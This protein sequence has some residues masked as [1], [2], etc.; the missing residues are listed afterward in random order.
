LRGA[1]IIAGA[2]VVD[3]EALLPRAVT[4]QAGTYAVIFG[5]GAFGA[6]GFADIGFNNI[7]TSGA[8]IISDNEN[9]YGDRWNTF[10]DEGAE[11]FVDGTLAAAV[12]E[13]SALAA[14]IAGLI[15]LG[16]ILYRRKGAM[17]APRAA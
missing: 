4:L 1:P 8:D 16:F 12:P 15:G 6:S 7:P 11:L 9:I 17:G 13:P 3:Y 5:S 14:M 2:P 10:N